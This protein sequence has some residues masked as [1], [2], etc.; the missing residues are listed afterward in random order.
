MQYEIDVTKED[1]KFVNTVV[2]NKGYRSSLENVRIRKIGGD[3]V[4]ETSDTHVLIRKSFPI[5]GI[6]FDNEEFD[7]QFKPEFFKRL[8]YLCKQKEIINITVDVGTLEICGKSTYCS[9]VSQAIA[10]DGDYP[11]TDKV[12]PEDDGDV[13]IIFKKEVLERLMNSLPNDEQFL[14]FSFQTSAE[15]WREPSVVRTGKNTSEWSKDRNLIMGVRPDG[16]QW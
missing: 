7:L 15:P 5:K 9:I 8:I 14:K 11:N 16:N 6:N 13:D 3:L 2:V 1:L 12:F 4:F 10:A